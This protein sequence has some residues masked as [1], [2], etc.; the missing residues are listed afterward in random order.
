MLVAPGR[1]KDARFLAALEPLTGKIDVDLMRQA[2]YLVDREEDK[3]TPEAAA[4][5]LAQQMEDQ[6]D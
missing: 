1:A 4:R 3:Q 5:W 6:G 2:N